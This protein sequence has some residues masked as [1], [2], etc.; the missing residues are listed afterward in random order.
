M[1]HADAGS[2]KSAKLFP[3]D[4]FI[5]IHDKSVVA[6]HQCGLSDRSNIIALQSNAAQLLPESRTVDA[7]G[8]GQAGRP[9]F[10]AL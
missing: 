1:V 10:V 4:F 3:K 8:G 7:Q 5:R 6:P 2:L 9:V